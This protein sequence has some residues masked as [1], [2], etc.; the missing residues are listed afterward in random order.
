MTAVREW[1]ERLKPFSDGTV[2][3]NYLDRDEAERAKEGF[4]PNYGRLCEVKRRY[5]PEGRFPGVLPAS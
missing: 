2:Y 1:F 5:D 3:L 4:G